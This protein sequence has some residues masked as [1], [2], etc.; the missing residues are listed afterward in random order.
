M[1]LPVLSVPGWDVIPG[2]VHGFLGRRG[3][4]GTGAYGA[5][6]L[7]RRTD[8]DPIV[9]SANWDRVRAHFGGVAIVTMRQVHGIRVHRVHEPETEPTETDA[10][11]SAATGVALGVLTADCVPVLMV[12]PVSRAVLAVHA[13]WRGTVDGIV[14]EAVSAAQREFGADPADL[15]VAL[16]PAISGCCY[17]VGAEIGS[18]LERRWGTMREAWQGGTTKGMLDLRRANRE[19]LNAAGVPRDRIVEVGPCTACHA[20]AFFSHRRSGGRTGRQLSVVGWAAD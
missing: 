4:V 5:L 2:L 16:G 17:E 10:L 19:I 20:D 12:D 7:G 13:G 6:N 3:G 18:E 1:S 15:H 8:D 11:A 9:V 14:A